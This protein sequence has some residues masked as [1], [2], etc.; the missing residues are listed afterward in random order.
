MP[1]LNRCSIWPQ[2]S[3]SRSSAVQGPPCVL[4]VG[5][6]QDGMRHGLGEILTSRGEAYQGHFEEDIML[7]PGWSHCTP[8][9]LLPLLH[10]LRTLGM[11][12]ELPVG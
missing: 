10:L 3:H 4:Y 12:K 8:L 9:P 7:G 11:V 1:A 2:P 6:F 5:S